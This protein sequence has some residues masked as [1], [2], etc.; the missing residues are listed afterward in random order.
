[1]IICCK[2]IRTIRICTFVICRISKFCYVKIANGIFCATAR[3]DK[4]N[5]S[6]FRNFTFILCH[7]SHLLVE[8]RDENYSS[9]SSTST[10]VN[11]I[12]KALI[13]LVEPLFSTFT[14]SNLKLL[15]TITLSSCIAEKL[16]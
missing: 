13:L 16:A 9:S 14:F 5:L 10:N 2:H 7:I 4:L 12:D 8:K 3:T 11:K 15:P 1:M 6:P